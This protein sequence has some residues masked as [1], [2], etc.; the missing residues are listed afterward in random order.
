MFIKISFKYL[1]NDREIKSLVV[2]VF[3]RMEIKRGREKKKAN[4]PPPKAEFA[5]RCF[6]GGDIK[7]K[8]N[9]SQSAKVIVHSLSEELQCC[10]GNETASLV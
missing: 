1:L 4:F 8:K 10:G 9:K 3:R 5:H 7:L 6:E 2:A